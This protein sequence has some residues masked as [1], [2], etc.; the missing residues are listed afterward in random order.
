MSQAVPP[1]SQLL[2]RARS[3]RGESLQLVWHSTPAVCFP[4]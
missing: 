1:W 3:I 2:G 4:L